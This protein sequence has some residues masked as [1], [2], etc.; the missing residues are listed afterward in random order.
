MGTNL[1]SSQPGA[2][3]IDG[4]DALAPMDIATWPGSNQAGAGGGLIALRRKPQGGWLAEVAI[5]KTTLTATGYGVATDLEGSRGVVGV[6]TQTVGGLAQRSEVTIVER[7][8]TTWS[9]VATLQPGTSLTGQRFGTALQLVG[10]RV[11]VGARRGG[12]G[13][14]NADAAVT[15]FRRQASGAWVEQAQIS[16]Q[17]CGCADDYGLTPVFAFDGD[18]LASVFANTTASGVGT[19]WW[20][21]HFK[22]RPELG[23]GNFGAAVRISGLIAPDGQPA[24]P[25][26]AITGGGGRFLATRNTY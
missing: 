14:T 10:D 9:I 20:E 26:A 7:N 11:F 15:V 8:N 5:P 13:V 2:V 22:L 16:G 12:C 19:G 3:A 21:R 18:R 4:D 6:D 24:I 17:S 1:T 25:I 23:N